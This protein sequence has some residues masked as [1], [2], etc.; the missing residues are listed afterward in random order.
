MSGISRTTRLDFAC[1]YRLIFAFAAS[2]KV[3]VTLLDTQ[4]VHTCRRSE[5]RRRTAACCRDFREVIQSC[6]IVMQQPAYPQQIGED[7]EVCSETLQVC[8]QSA[9]SGVHGVVTA[10][11]GKAQVTQV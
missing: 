9:L 4:R 3:T 8:K 7:T 1:I 2:G 6:D 11:Y 5:G 10:L